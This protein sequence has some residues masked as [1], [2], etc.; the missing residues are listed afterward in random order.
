MVVSRQVR[1]LVRLIDDLLDVS[2]ITRGKIELRKERVDVRR[3][4]RPS[5][6]VRPL[7]DAR[8]HESDVSLPPDGLPVEADPTPAGAGLSNLLN[9]AAKYTD[10]GGRIALSAEREGDRGG[11]PGPRHRHRH[12]APSMLPARLR[13]VH[14]GRRSLDRSQGGLGIG[15]TVVRSLLEAA[16]RQPHRLK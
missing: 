15:L 11:R 8:Q 9:N 3:R 12:L 2:R 13:P 16:R 4:G 6:S 5:R 1:H 10:R 14:P 7:I